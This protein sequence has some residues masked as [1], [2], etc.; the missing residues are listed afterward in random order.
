MQLHLVRE[1]AFFSEGPRAAV[2]DAAECLAYDELLLSWADQ[3]RPEFGLLRLWEAPSSFVVLGY[4]KSVA[5]DVHM[6][7]CAEDGVPIL[8][9]CS[10]GGT[11]LQTIGCLSY[12]LILPT[13]LSP[14]L[15]TIQSTTSWIMSA[16]AQCLEGFMGTAV[17]VRGT[18]DLTVGALKISGNAQRRGRQSVLFHGTVLCQVDIAEMGRYLQI[19]SYQPAYRQNRSHH[20]F[21][22]SI[23]RPPAEL[24]AHLKNFWV[25]TPLYEVEANLPYQRWADELQNVRTRYLSADYVYLR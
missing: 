22:M 21:L 23:D 1:P 5:A 8:R 17:S 6:S 12:S 3:A 20:D 14:E 24:S 13:A 15:A 19:P 25:D 2:E 11:V 18:S 7:H 4:G 16:Q 10:G 9:R